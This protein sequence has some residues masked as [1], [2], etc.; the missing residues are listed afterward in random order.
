VFVRD[1]E[2]KWS[3]QAYVKASNS[4]GYDYFG[5]DLALSATGNTLAVGAYWEDSSA[6]G[7]DGDQADN[8]ANNSG[9][10]YVFV[11]DGQGQWSQ[12]AYVKAS[13]TD[14]LDSFGCSVALAA[15]GDTLAVGAA[16]ENGGAEG[17]DGDPSK[18]F[19]VE[20]GAAY[21]FVRYGQGQWSQQAYVKASNPSSDWFGRNLALSASGTTLALLV[22]V[23]ANLRGENRLS[24]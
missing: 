17:I 20:F 12:Q 23:R 7:I 9:A 21:V 6:T 8:S 15:D 2:G 19:N 10:G 16:W 11:R 14:P 22:L 4:D 5:V 13:N 1:P 24:Q 3:Q 18:L